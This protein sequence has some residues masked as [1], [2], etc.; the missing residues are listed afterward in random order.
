[1]DTGLRRLT[2]A[3]LVAVP[4]AAVMPWSWELQPLVCS[5]LLVWAAAYGAG[6]LRQRG[7]RRLPK[8]TR[9]R[10]LSFT[11]GMVLLALALLSPLEAWG[12]ALFAGHMVQ[13]LILMM[14]APPLLILGRP[15]VVALW[16]LPRGRRHFVG[17]WW[18]HN[19]W[20]RPAYELLVMPLSAWLLASAALWFWHLPRPYALAFHYPLAHA[21]EHLSFFFTAVLFWRVVIDGPRGGRISIAATMIFV[22]SYAMQ[23]AMLAAILIF[24]PR[25]L[26]GVHALGPLWSPLTPL[27]DQ[28]LAGV[29]M[30]AVMGVVD[31]IA[32]CLLFV[33]WL[34][35]AA[36]KMAHT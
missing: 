18:L 11:A 3:Q 17:A 35:S 21:A 7:E 10:A 33:A 2:G 4:G 12:D 9:W 20:S 16:A 31:L 1:M 26:Y 29:L 36:R 15:V 25:V 34:A 8:G 22:L 28:Q 14:L 30:W 6:L 32:L 24:A 13:H 27:E 23:S 19:R 5:L